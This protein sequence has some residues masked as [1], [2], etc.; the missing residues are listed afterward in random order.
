MQIFFFNCFGQNAIKYNTVTVFL[1]DY[2][3]LSLGQF[4][5]L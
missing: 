5:A 2:F 1:P 4:V 3:G